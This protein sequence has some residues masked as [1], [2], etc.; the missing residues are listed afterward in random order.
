M[1]YSSQWRS[2]NVIKR[3]FILANRI[4]T[5][6]ETGCKGLGIFPTAS[7]IQLFAF[8][9]ISIKQLLKRFSWSNPIVSCLIK[10]GF[11]SS[12]HS[13]PGLCCR[14]GVLVPFAVGLGEKICLIISVLP[15][16]CLFL[17]EE[18]IMSL[19]RSRTFSIVFSLAGIVNVNLSYLKSLL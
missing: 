5:I 16:V 12:R 14:K 4:A 3:S 10:Q 7:F 13:I 6:L 9:L 19:L 11:D 18:R 1:F 17:W 2:C 15:T 8:C